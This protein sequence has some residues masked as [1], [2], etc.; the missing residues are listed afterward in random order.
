[1]LGASMD[2]KTGVGTFVADTDVSFSDILENLEMGFMGR[3]RASRDVW[4]FGTDIIY[5]GLGADSDRPDVDID[6]DQLAFELNAGYQLAPN[7]VALAGVRYNE[8]KVKLDFQGIG[9]V[10]SGSVDWWDPIV[11]GIYTLPINDRWDFQAHGDVGGFGVGSDLAWQIEL[12]FHWNF[13]P[14][15][16]VMMGYRWVDTDYD[17]DGFKYDVLSQGPQLGATLHF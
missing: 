14:R 11:G 6:V 2:G 7:F 15:T 12:L 3:A 8:L 9:R 16:S 13:S 1:M 5:M 10:S 17:D 4:S